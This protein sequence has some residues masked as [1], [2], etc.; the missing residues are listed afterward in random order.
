M[1]TLNVRLDNQLKQSAYAVLD[2]LGISPSEA[3]RQYFEFIS[4]NKCLPIATAVLDDELLS[5]VRER[6]ADPQPGIKI[7]LDEL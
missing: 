7:S 5:I 4:V 1:A 3:I 2:E 6:L